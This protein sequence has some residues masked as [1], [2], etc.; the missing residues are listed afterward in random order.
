MGQLSHVEIILRHSR[1]R[2]ILEITLSIVSLIIHVDSAFYAES[3]ITVK[4]VEND[5]HTFFL[6]F[7]PGLIIIMI[8]TFLVAATSLALVPP[9]I[10]LPLEDEVS[11]IVSWTMEFLKFHLD[12]ELFFISGVYPLTIFDFKAL[13]FTTM[14]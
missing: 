6:F 10:T 2:H 5:F 14:C 12:N 9:S 4:V 3:P 7:L 13:V 8:R 1:D 11:D